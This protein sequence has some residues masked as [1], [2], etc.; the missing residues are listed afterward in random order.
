MD[1]ISHNCVSGRMYQQKNIANG[2]PFVWC[3]ITPDDFWYMY[4]NYDKI[5]F[6]NIEIGKDKSSIKITID[7]KVSV[8]YPHYKYSRDCQ[9]PTKKSEIDIFY[10]K[11]DEFVVEKYR[12]RLKRMVGNP[13]FIVTDREFP[14]LTQYNFSKNDLMKYVGRK[15]CVVAVYDKSIEGN[16]VIYLPK[17]NMDPKEI[18]E[19]I[20]K[21][22]DQ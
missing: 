16:N 22:L 3:M 12:T 14:E 21:K 8:L 15:D 20:L 5:N 6:N 17:K 19:I 10:N 1:F 11:I 7:G 2:N 18:S 4:C 13:L 9:N